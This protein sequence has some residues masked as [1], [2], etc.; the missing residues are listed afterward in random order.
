MSQRNVDAVRAI[1]ERWGRGDFTASL[2]VMDPDV[3]FVMPPE[4]PDPGT[5][6]GFEQLAQ[7]MHGFLEPWTHI[8]IEAEEITDAG[9][10]VVAAVR[11]HG[12]GSGS[13]IETEI[14]YFQTWV[15]RGPKVVRL[16]N[17]RERS[18]AFEA[19]GLAAD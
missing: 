3:V 14:R 11:Q 5:Y 9:E 15:F 12:T 10:G 17:S 6:R 16:E 18:K 2:E 8:A 13:G 1:Y 7:Y 19:A 4:L